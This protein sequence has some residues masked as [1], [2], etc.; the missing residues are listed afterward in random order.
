MQISEWISGIE[1]T[2]S[3]FCHRIIGSHTN[4]ERTWNYVK[5]RSNQFIWTNVWAWRTNAFESP[6]IGNQITTKKGF[7][8]IESPLR[9]F[10]FL[11]SHSQLCVSGERRKEKRNEPFNQFHE[12]WHSWANIHNVMFFF[13]RFVCFTHTHVSVCRPSERAAI[14][15]KYMVRR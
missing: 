1:T 5:S 9:S 10:F 2:V 15:G 12:V 3:G 6:K 7:Y 4:F 11:S 13:H 8:A 14:V